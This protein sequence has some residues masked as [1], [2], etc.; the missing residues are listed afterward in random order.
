MG[1]DRPFQKYEKMVHPYSGLDPEN[2]NRFLTNLRGFEKNLDKDLDKASDFLYHSIENIRDLGLGVR[3]SADNSIQDTLQGIGNMLG[4]E[5]ELKINQI[6]IKK[7]L[8]FF[9]KYLNETF[10]DYPE[11]GYFIPSTVRSHGQ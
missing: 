11:D 7:G 1:A 2:W 9:P 8:Y 3:T 5:G 10:D 4:T 6:A